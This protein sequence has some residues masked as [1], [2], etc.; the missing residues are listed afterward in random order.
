MTEPILKVEGIS[1]GFPGVQALKDVHLSV[2][3]G[4]VLVLREARERGPVSVRWWSAGAPSLMH[5][6]FIVADGSTGYFGTANL[7]S[8]GLSEH[9]EMGVA[10]APTQAASLLSLLEQ[11]EGAG[12]F[13]ADT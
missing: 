12:L 11:L 10:L 6:K 1:K 4:E 7:T 3:A 13:D 5:A 8:L 9:L 2:F